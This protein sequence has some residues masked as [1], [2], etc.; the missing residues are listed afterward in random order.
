MRL[1]ANHAENRLLESA[2]LNTALIAALNVHMK[3][4]HEI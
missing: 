4:G 1:Y 2:M 3:A